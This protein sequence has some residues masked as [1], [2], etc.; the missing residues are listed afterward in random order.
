MSLSTK[1]RQLLFFLA[2]HPNQVFSASMLYD[3]IWGLEGTS[4][5]NTVSVHIRYLRKKIERNPS[6]PKYIQTVR[7]FGYKLCWSDE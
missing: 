6:Q 2:N 4:E 5:E 3:R 7:G 1:E